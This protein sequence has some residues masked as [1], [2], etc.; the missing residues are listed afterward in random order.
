VAV[1]AVVVVAVVAVVVVAVVV[2]IVDVDVGVDVDVDVGVDGGWQR[3]RARRSQHYCLNGVHRC[4][5]YVWGRM[6]RVVGIGVADAVGGVVE[7]RERRAS[8]HEEYGERQHHG[9]EHHG[10]GL[11]GQR[12]VQGVLQGVLQ[13]VQGVLQGVLQRVLQGVWQGVWQGVLQG[14]WQGVLGEGSGGGG[15]QALW[16]AFF[17]Q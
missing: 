3:G 13:G 1:V 17:S 5:Y 6:W 4:Y 10:H 16:L 11:E 2:D 9:S 14:V 7:G 15:S 12:C 8:P